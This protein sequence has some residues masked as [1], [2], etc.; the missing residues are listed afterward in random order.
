MTTI[1]PRQ[2]EAGW[3]SVGRGRN[4]IASMKKIIAGILVLTAAA[5]APL[6]AQNQDDDIAQLKQRVA[7]LEKQVQE[8]SQ[9]IEPL[10][11]QLAAEKRR[12]ALRE[13]FDRKMEKDSQKYS[14]EQL[15]EAEQLYQIANQKWGTPEA[16]GSLQ[17]MIEK[18]PDINRTGCAVLYLAQKS[19]GEERAKHL[20]E[21]IAKYGDSFYGDGVQVGAYAR[22]LLAGDYRGKGELA[23]ADALENE[24]KAQFADAVDHGGR[25]LV[26]G[27][28]A[29]A[30][31]GQK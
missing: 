4:N 26:D 22:F 2:F 7:Q 14:R 23:K 30:K 20:G 25:L 6:F 21:C 27:L 11:A 12:K 29:A 19:E 1:R 17:K 10:K 28:T 9:L 13:K 8:M 16:A 18:Y 5:S 15:N 3:L 24:I 31:E